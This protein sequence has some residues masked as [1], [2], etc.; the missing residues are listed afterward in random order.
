LTAD[1]LS[2]WLL[3]MDDIAVAMEYQLMVDGQIHALRAD[4]DDRYKN[5]SPGTYLNYRLLSSLFAG[6]FSRYYMGPGKNPYKSRW[7]KTS[8]PVKSLTSFSPTVRGRAGELWS[9]V[10]PKLR[11]WKDRLTR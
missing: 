9:Q 8:E 2:V 10:K 5:V 6:G 1:W 7:S 11:V 4:F 3:R